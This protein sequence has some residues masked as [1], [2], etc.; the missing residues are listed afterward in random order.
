[1]I[2]AFGG[3]RAALVACNLRAAYSGMSPMLS[4]IHAATRCLSVVFSPH[5]THSV[6]ICG[7]LLQ[8]PWSVCLSVS[9]QDT[10]V[11][12]AKTAEPIKMPFGGP[13]HVSSRIHCYFGGTLALP[14]EYDWT[15]KTAAVWAVTTVTVAT[16]YSYICAFLRICRTLTPFMAKCRT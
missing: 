4:Y 5:D 3:R 9:A 1:M 15:L 13:T 10:T 11:S 14:G 7:V 2:K 6:Y 16:C 8:M 12:L